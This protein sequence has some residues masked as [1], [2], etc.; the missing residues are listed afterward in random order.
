MDST[1]LLRAKRGRRALLAAL[2]LLCGAQAALARPMVPAERREYSFSGRLPACNDPSVLST[3]SSRFQ[4]RE[5]RYWESGLAIAAYDRIAE[6]GMR[7]PGLDFIPRR[8]CMARALFNDGSARKV[9]FAIVEKMGW[10]GVLGFGVQW[11][12]DGLDRN[13][14]FGD[15]CRAARP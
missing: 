9:N 11:C 2:A 3:I 7:S 8:Y 6:I 12:V 15:E 4:S 5:D 1:S 13:R 10:L 14:A